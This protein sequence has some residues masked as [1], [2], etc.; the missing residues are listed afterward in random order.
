MEK[1]G[2]KTRNVNLIVLVAL[3]LL[4]AGAGLLGMM[5]GDEF[6]RRPVRAGN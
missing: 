5:L 6:L 3:F 4:A 1:F 2:V